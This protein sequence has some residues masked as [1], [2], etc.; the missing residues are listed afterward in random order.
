MK[1]IKKTSRN[2]SGTVYDLTVENT[3]SYNVEGCAVHNSVV[4]SLVAY[5][6]GITK[7]DPIKHDLLFERF[8]NR[9][10]KA[11]PD[12]DLDFSKSKRDL[13]KKYLK[14]KYGEDRVAGISNWS[15]LSPKVVIKDVARS[16]NIEG[17]KKATFEVANYIT[18]IM[19]EEKTIE[20][21]ESK[22]KKFQSYMVSYPKLRKHAIEL[23]GLVR[24]W[25]VHA[26]GVVISDK[27]LVELTPLRVDE[28]GDMILQ[29]EKTRTE[30]FGLVKMDLL[31]LDTLD[32]I[33]ETIQLIEKH[34]GI[35]IDIDKI[36]TDDRETF[37]MIGRG[38]TMG[39][40]QLESSL[41]PLCMKIKP[42]SIDD[43]SDINALGRPSCSAEQRQSYIERKMGAEPITY[44][45]PNLENALKKTFG[46]SLYEEAM[47][48]VAKDCAGWDLNQSDALRK[49]TKLKG[50]DPELVEKTRNTFINDSVKFSGMSSKEAAR[51]WEHE[52][53]P[54]GS[55][56][57]NK[58]HSVAYSYISYQTAW[59]KCH[60]PTEYMC[61]LLNSEDPNSDKLLEYIQEC[62][63][64]AIKIT[65]PNLNTSRYNYMVTGSKS[66]ATGLSAIKGIGPKALEEILSLQPFQNLEDFFLRTNA[67]VI[68]KGVIQA[69]A[70][71]GVFETFNRTRKDIFEN[72]EQYRDLVRAE[73]KKGKTIDLI[74]LPSYQ[75]E[76][77]RKQFLLSEREVYGRTISGSLH[78]IFKGFFRANSSVTPLRKIKD[79]QPGDRVKIEVIINSKIKEFTVKKPGKNFGKKF[80]KYLV[81]DATGTTAEFT[82]WMDDYQKYNHILQDGLPLKAVCKIDEYM[83]QRSLSLSTLEGVLGKEI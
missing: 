6:T 36:P 78:E 71:A 32:V 74:K 54:Y 27:P 83:E 69:L 38:Q 55:Y 79:M 77:D 34:K 33:A 46:I 49:I 29:W 67:R 81:E 73:I 10:K 66:I 52:I 51:I 20:E 41:A 3:H 68:N 64:M 14:T 8:H 2:Y 39:V 16:L 21:I 82:V 65:P 13:V 40:F 75:E 63:K 47:M 30:E 80:A 50:K 60:Y 62:S 19:L 26:A 43:I 59:L 76:W 37:E 4:G 72:Y 53:E 9:E 17:D 42:K 22:S 61:A 35:K 18:S 5:L 70:K 1:L 44:L 25:G 12:I 45:H 15:T 24:N 57:F 11:Y 28:D 7:V 56:G 31:G 58:A 48:T 23:Q